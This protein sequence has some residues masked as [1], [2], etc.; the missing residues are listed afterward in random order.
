VR[1]QVDHR[2]GPRRRGEVLEEAIMR[3]ALAEL[4]EVGYVGVSMERIAT[5]ART[6][7]A[8]LY[9]RWPDRAH[10]IVDSYIRFV[11][12]DVQIPDTGSL[13]GDVINLLR[14]LVDLVGSPMV[15]MLHGL[16]SDAA[17]NGELRGVIREHVATIK[18][19]L[20]A[21]ILDRAR[22]R[23]EIRHDLTRRQSTVPLELMRGEILMHDGQVS[24]QAIEEIVDEVFL[25]LVQ[26]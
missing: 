20:M 23:G 18:P 26:R 7:K 3:A 4:A 11:V 1:V 15:V 13:R 17:H 14:Q 2:K 12:Q 25:P 22:A 8:A 24:D 9:R 19:W 21:D 6:S 16:M 10:L 5:R